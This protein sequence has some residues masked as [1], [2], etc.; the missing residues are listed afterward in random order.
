MCFTF[1][2]FRFLLFSCLSFVLPV[3]CDYFSN[4]TDCGNGEQFSCVEWKASDGNP[5]AQSG[6]S[7]RLTSLKTFIDWSFVWFANGYF[8]TRLNLKFSVILLNRT[9]SPK[10]SFGFELFPNK[11]SQP[12]LYRINQFYTYNYTID[13]SN[14]RARSGCIFD[15][16]KGEW[17][18][19]S[20]AHPFN[21]YYPEWTKPMS[22]IGQQ[23]CLFDRLQNSLNTMI[24]I[25][26]RWSIDM[27]SR[28]GEYW[29]KMQPFF[30]PLPQKPT[31]PPSYSDMVEWL[32][33][34]VAANSFSPKNYTLPFS[35]KL[36]QATCLKENLHCF[37]L[38]TKSSSTLYNANNIQCHHN[39]VSSENKPNGCIFGFVHY[40]FGENVIVA[41][42]RSFALNDSFQ[43]DYQFPEHADLKTKTVIRFHCK[44]NQSPS[45]VIVLMESVLPL[46]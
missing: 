2:I 11:I 12:N 3:L 43:I 8:G 32:R 22:I 20:E 26:P 44:R 15:E 33:R 42:M 18:S 41:F 45:H 39:D 7:F 37:F 17:K 16:I 1:S 29:Y 40:G 34:E 19:F 4:P 6:H 13:D 27:S 31:L 46:N 30:Y 5:L 23:F 10:T 35:T 24:V 36:I 21:S 9:I 38:H 28:N 25:D 14:R